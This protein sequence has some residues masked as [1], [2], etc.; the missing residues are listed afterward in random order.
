MRGQRLLVVLAVFVV[1]ATL[2][3][4][5]IAI[6]TG[7]ADALGVKAHTGSGSTADLPPSAR[8]DLVAIFG[9]KVKKFGLRVTRAALV[10][11]KNER[12][13]RGTHLAIYVEPT[14][15]YTPQDYI[16]GTVDVSRVF[17]PYVFQRWKGLQSFDVCQEPHPE[18]DDRLSP[19][20][21]TQVFASRA[22]NKK[23]DWPTVDVA[24]LV[25]DSNTEAAAAGA[26]RPVAVSLY[27][28]AHLQLTPAY[29]SA[30]GDTTVGDA[31]ATTPAYG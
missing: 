4:A 13:A 11:P 18:V 28:A 7:T 29:Q 30:V 17:L 16:D 1:P 31:P 25:A 19:P 12:S 26:A 22:A 2:L 14:G 8:K 10:N 5:P 24:T 6:L 21:E 23:I 15:A 3:L 20:P 9:P 27:V